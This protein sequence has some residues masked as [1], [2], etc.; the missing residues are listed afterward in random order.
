MAC[1]YGGF[2]QKLKENDDDSLISKVQNYY[3]FFW[4]STI[5]STKPFWT[6]PYEDAFGLGNIVTV[7]IPIFENQTDSN[8]LIK[9]IGVAGIDVL[10]GQLTKYHKTE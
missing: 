1:Y 2:V 8:K 9:M 7:S 10:M 4:Q 6:D 5:N 3:D